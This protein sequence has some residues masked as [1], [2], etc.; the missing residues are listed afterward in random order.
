MRISK[1]FYDIGLSFIS[2]MSPAIVHFILRVTL[3]RY[4]GSSDLGIYSIVYAF[5]SFGLVVCTFGVGAALIKFIAEFKDDKNKTNKLFTSGCLVSVIAGC[6]LGFL[7]FLLA[8]LLANFFDIPSLDRL[9]KIL[10]LSF[11]FLAFEKCVLGFLNGQKK[12]LLYAYIRVVENLGNIFLS[13]AFISMGWGLGGVVWALVISLAISSVYAFIKIFNSIIILHWVEFLD[14]SKVLLTFGK[15]VVLTN[16]INNLNLYASTLIVGYFMSPHEVGCFAVA[17]IFVDVMR[18]PF[19]AVQMVTNPTLSKYWACREMHKIEYLI[20]ACIRYSSIL[21][22]FVS[23]TLIFGA[24]LF[25][26]I[27]FGADF[28]SV[29]LVLQL[30]LVGNVLSC[31]LITVGTALSSTNFVNVAF[32]L[33]IVYGVI[34]IFLILLL[35]P[36]WGLLGAAL[37]STIS[38]SANVCISLFATE[39]FVGIKIYMS[40]LIK[41]CCCAGLIVG[42][43]YILGMVINSFSVYILSILLLAI[44]IYRYFLSSEDV[45][46][47][48]SRFS[49]SF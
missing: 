11:P 3:G 34:N 2:L 35:V 49:K 22:I 19:Q 17:M 39:R 42:L 9:L 21:A 30:L 48:R 27:I 8:P 4:F 29:V 12:M 33:G 36:F 16:G 47:I 6:F 14:S 37:A 28:E 41:L 31:I 46:F 23:S 32:K 15:Y 20:N 44:C 40:W 1:N 5:Y 10:S 45:A 25:I 18:L 26:N 7:L 38:W 24:E 13:I 43:F